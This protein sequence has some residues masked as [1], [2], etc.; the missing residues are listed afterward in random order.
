MFYFCVVKQQMACADL[1][2]TGES[3]ISKSNYKVNQSNIHEN[4]EKLQQGMYEKKCKDILVTR[5]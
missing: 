3:K 1:M 2:G 5:E 4:L